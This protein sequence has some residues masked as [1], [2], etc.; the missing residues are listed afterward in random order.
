MGRDTSHGAQGP[1]QRGLSGSRGPSPSREHARFFKVRTFVLLWA[2]EKHSLLARK[3]QLFFHIYPHHLSPS[4]LYLFFHSGY[5][6]LGFL[7]F[8]FLHALFFGPE[9]HD[10]PQYFLNSDWLKPFFLCPSF[11]LSLSSFFVFFSPQCCPYFSLISSFYVL[12][13]APNCKSV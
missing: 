11:L 6:L 8:Y 5:F 9:T 7:C 13:G 10:V 2:Q 3:K 1:I 12:C 4:F